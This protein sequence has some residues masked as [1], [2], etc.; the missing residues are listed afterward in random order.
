MALRS[1]PCIPDG[2]IQA[3]DYDDET[4]ELYI[5]FQRQDQQYKYASVGQVVADGFQNSGITAG[6][7]FRANILN[8]YGYERIG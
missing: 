8:Q 2:N 5:T 6:R 1:I 4:S 3:V 7:F